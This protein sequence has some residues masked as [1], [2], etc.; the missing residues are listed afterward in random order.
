MVRRKTC[1]LIVESNFIAQWATILASDGCQLVHMTCHH[2]KK[3]EKILQSIIKTW[4][5]QQLGHKL[6]NARTDRQQQT[7]DILVDFWS[8]PI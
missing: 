3:N 2:A 8:R 4:Q 5:I 7:V 1:L 6:R